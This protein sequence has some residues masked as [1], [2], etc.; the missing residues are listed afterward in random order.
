MYPACHFGRNFGLVV[1]FATHILA[2]AISVDIFSK[3]QHLKVGW[4]AAERL[5]AP[6]TDR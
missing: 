5:M 2:A 4:V 3:R 6:V 1:S